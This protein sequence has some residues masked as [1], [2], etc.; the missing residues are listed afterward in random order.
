MTV[1]V[2]MTV[3][4]YL[5]ELFIFKDA[6]SV[7]QLQRALQRSLGARNPPP[8]RQQREAGTNK[9]FSIQCAM[10]DKVISTP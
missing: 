3:T 6:E 8:D 2:S 1:T 4:F 5:F 7:K 10:L 9:D